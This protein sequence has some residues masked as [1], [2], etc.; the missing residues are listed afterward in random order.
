MTWEPKNK[1]EDE[2]VEVSD[3]EDRENFPREDKSGGH[4]DFL[5]FFLLFSKFYLQVTRRRGGR[6]SW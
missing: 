2:D 5:S 3:D 6:G 1:L 4:Q